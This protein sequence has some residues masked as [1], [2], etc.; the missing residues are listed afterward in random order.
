[1]KRIETAAEPILPY[2]PPITQVV[3]VAHI[4]STKNT[5]T[6]ATHGFGS[7]Q[8]LQPDFKRGFT[9]QRKHRTGD[10]DLWALRVLTSQARRPLPNIMRSPAQERTNIHLTPTWWFRSVV[11]HLLSK[12]AGVQTPKPKP[13]KCELPCN[14]ILQ[15]KA[16]L[17]ILNNAAP[18]TRVPSK[19]ASC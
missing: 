17:P 8:V 6:L 2:Y 4:A 14:M 13:P 19:F 1:M 15:M 10:L 7:V 11:P 16:L 9:P 3:I 5:T 18:N 12:G